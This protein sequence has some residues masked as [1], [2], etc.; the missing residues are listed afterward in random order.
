M[1][2]KENVMEYLTMVADARVKLIEEIK[3][4]VCNYDCALAGLMSA[5]AVDIR[6]DNHARLDNL[7]TVEVDREILDLVPEDKLEITEDKYYS[8]KCF[9]YNGITLKAQYFKEQAYD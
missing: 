8:Y 5:F 4:A 3:S 2:N 6:F 9:K 7:N 1:L